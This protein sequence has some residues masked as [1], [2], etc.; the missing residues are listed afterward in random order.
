M[1]HA[2]VHVQH[3]PSWATVTA[4]DGGAVT[5]T[6]PPVAGGGITMASL[7]DGSPATCPPVAGGGITMA[8]LADGSSVTGTRGNAPGVLHGL[9]VCAD[10]PGNAPGVLG[11][12]SVDGKIPDT[13][14]G[15]VG[16]VQVSDDAA[17]NAPG[18]LSAESDCCCKTAAESTSGVL[19][20]T[21]GTSSG[22]VSGP[23]GGVGCVSLS[24]TTG[25]VASG[26]RARRLA[27]AFPRSSLFA[28]SCKY[29]LT[30]T[31]FS[32]LSRHLRRRWVYNFDHELVR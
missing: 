15:V 32:W 18:V 22:R 25:G 23:V 5:A 16:G 4:D 7:A 29:E 17:V 14:P 13:A 3:V 11:G 1:Q 20:G 27:C 9:S 31:A 30:S 10:A 28:C 6:G 24:L 8:S 2:C 12:P 19:V 21:R 26:S